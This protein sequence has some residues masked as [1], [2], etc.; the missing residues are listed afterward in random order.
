MPEQDVARA[1]REKKRFVL[2]PHYNPDGDAVGSVLALADILDHMGKETL[3]FFEAPVPVIYRFLPGAGRAITDIKT[4]RAFFRA[5]GDEGALVTLDCGDDR[6]VGKH[7]EELLAYH[8]VVVIDHHHSNTGFGDYNWV[9]GDS[10]ATG[11]MVF[12]LARTL[13]ARI[14]P[15]AASCLYSAISTDTGSF[16]YAARS[17]TFEAAAELV[18]LG[19]DPADLANKLYNNY[20]LGRLRLMREVLA[21][22]E[23]YERD[24]IAFI[25]VSKSMRD[26]TF[27]T[28]EDIEYF[29]NY[30][31]AIQSVRA[32]VFL[33]EIEPGK[34]SVSL[35]A[36][37]QCDVS[38]IAARFGGGGHKNAAGCTFQNVPG[39]DAVRDALLPP[40]AAAVSDTAETV[41]A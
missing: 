16:H 26:R 1:L 20:S 32:A 30:P 3:C 40:L 17:R 33:K 41:A 34:V 8:P 10:A 13:D 18:R 37:G 6:R 15:E 12:R 4:V 31:R 9:D 19:A 25:R 22:L 2:C 11:E 29:V 7:R 38:A 24:R 23:M 27:T 36:K 35:R 5:A 39:M 28:M 21:T 14:S